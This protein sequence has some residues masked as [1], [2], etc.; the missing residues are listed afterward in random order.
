MDRED[1]R[2]VLG[3]YETSRKTVVVAEDGLQEHE[4]RSNHEEAMRIL[5]GAQARGLAEDKLRERYLG[6]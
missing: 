3:L 1:A 5:F 4:M 2:R 6:K